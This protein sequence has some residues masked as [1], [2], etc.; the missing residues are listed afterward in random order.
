MKII[1]ILTTAIALAAT[2]GAFAEQYKVIVPLDED[3]NGAQAVLLNYDTGDEIGIVTVA[4]QAA[5]FK[6]EIDEP[7]IARVNIDGSRG[8]VFIL[9]SGTISFNKNQEAFGTMYNDQM[10]A[11]S[12]ELS[13]IVEEYRAAATDEAQEAAYNKYEAAL[14]KA[15]EENGDNI[16]GYYCFL[17]GDASQ[18][19][20]A[21]L[22]ETF[23]KYPSFANYARAKKYLESAEKREATQPGKKFLDFEVT[24][25]GKTKRLS[26]YVG[27]G[28]Y[29]L[30]DFWA[31]W[32]GPC[33]RQTEVLK[34]IYKKYDRDRLDVLGVAVW[35][36]PEDTKRAIKDHDLPW[37]SILDAQTIPTDL[38]GISG[39]PC[40]ILFGPDGTILSRDKQSE[41]LIADVDKELAKTFKA[42]AT[43][44]KTEPAPFHH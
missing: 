37:E 20:A 3:S 24:Y 10:R 16:V 32:C 30:V 7:I 4:D 19:E 22:R 9:E 11:I 12:A 31:S 36:D 38:Y 25:N 18:M 41:E 14:G 15:M 2:A 43:T 13:K 34:Q 39:I 6:G 28:K 26:D 21:E 35:D 23:K 27:K 8:P 5:K 40:I 1:K 33:I 29:M 44:I 17:N 42:P